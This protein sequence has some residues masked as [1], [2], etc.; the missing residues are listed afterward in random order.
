LV[1]RYIGSEH[2]V[3]KGEV[4]DTTGTRSQQNDAIVLNEHH[5]P[6]S[7]IFTSGP[8]LAEAITW[9]IEVKPDLKDPREL[10]RGLRQV[11]SIKRLVRRLSGGDVVFGAGPN[12]RHFAERIPTFL[13]AADSPEI[14]QLAQNIEE[15]YRES[16][17]EKILQLDAVFVLNRGVVYNF[18]E[19]GEDF[20]FEIDGDRSS[21]A[22]GFVAGQPKH[23][24]LASFL[25][26]LALTYRM[27]ITAFYV[28]DLTRMEKVS[29]FDPKLLYSKV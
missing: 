3:V 16:G 20:T 22:L 23:S 13:V 25:K 6:I 18:K 29:Y 17:E 10:K 9:A 1:L 27:N 21:Y 24:L 28:E 8:F 2:R 12:Y 4:I 5:P 14:G 19:P 26:T 11:T 15:N 7:G